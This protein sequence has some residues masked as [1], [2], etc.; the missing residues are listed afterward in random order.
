MELFKDSLPILIAAPGILVLI[1][2]EI[3]VSNLHGRHVYSVKGTLTNA[4]LAA[5]NVGLDVLMRATW[6]GV[7]SWGYQFHFA[8]MSNPWA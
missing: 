4:Y 2:V 8:R 6:F 1:G 7:L 3:A 5:V